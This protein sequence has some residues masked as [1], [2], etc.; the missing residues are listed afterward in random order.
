MVDLSANSRRLRYAQP[1]ATVMQPFW[2]HEM[3]CQ[4]AGMSHLWSMRVSIEIGQTRLEKLQQLTGM[5]EKSLAVL[6]ALKEY[7]G[8]HERRAF[9]KGAGR[10]N[11]LFCVK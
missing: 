11:R 8:G 7:L 6:F 9:P 1:P 10:R 2:L 5:Q 3:R 4:T